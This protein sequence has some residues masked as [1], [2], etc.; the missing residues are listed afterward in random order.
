M[1]NIQDEEGGA[2]PSEAPRVQRHVTIRRDA[3]DLSRFES[4]ND[5]ACF[6]THKLHHT[7][8]P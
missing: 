5:L 8:N 1:S 6:F 7:A 4:D 3:D 2:H